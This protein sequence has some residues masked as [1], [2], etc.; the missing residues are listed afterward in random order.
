MVSDK[1]ISEFATCDTC[2]IPVKLATELAANPVTDA[3]NDDS[4][5]F[6]AS[7]AGATQRSVTATKL[8][9]LLYVNGFFLTLPEATLSNGFPLYG[10]YGYCIVL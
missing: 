9:V 1:L 7:A 5:I 2:G 4:V 8:D 3:A 10:V 6:D